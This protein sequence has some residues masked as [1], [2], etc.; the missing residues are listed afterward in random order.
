MVLH[1]NSNLYSGRFSAQ[2]LAW[3]TKSLVPL[4]LISYIHADAV[5]R[6]IS[7]SLITIERFF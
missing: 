4:N 1:E 7:R 5:W 6:L 2:V 3:L